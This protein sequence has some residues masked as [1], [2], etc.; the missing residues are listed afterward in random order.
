MWKI[1]KKIRSCLQL[2]SKVQFPQSHAGS[3]N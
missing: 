1:K 3:N 2:E